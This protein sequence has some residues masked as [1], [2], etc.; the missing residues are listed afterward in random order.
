M[1]RFLRIAHRGA[2]G[3]FPENTQ[4]AFEKA[5]EAHA[6]MIE[7]DCQLCGDGHVVV[8]H[9]ETLWRRAAVRGL[10]REQTLAQLQQLQIGGWRRRSL[11]RQRILKLEEA[12][13]VIGGRA[14]LCIDIKLFA[15]SHPGIELKLLFILSHYDYLERTIFSSF[16]YRCLG[17]VRELAPEA[18]IGLIYSRA[19]KEDPFVA[20]ERLGAASIHLDKRAA[21]GDF[22]KH[23]WE[24]GLDVYL[25]TVNRPSEI[26]RFAA[27]GVQGIFSDF[28]ERLWLGRRF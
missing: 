24:K 1:S 21:S 18:R 16:D 12:I 14:D 26:E 22:L 19:V 15:R 17:R 2:S 10:V 25:W 20:A 28:P 5:L 4:I 23:A 6:D 27:L 3:Q 11:A 9:D 7:L 8:F 13:E